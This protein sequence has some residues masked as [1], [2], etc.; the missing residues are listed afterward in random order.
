MK[1]EYIKNE[2]SDV[3]K[4]NNSTRLTVTTRWPKVTRWVRGK[5]WS[6]EDGTE[7]KTKRNLHVPN[8]CIKEYLHL[9]STPTNSH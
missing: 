9:C 2:C 8:P 7:W 5:T 4:I 3:D 6:K 1:R